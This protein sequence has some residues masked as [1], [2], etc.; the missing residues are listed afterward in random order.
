MVPDAGFTISRQSHRFVDRPMTYTVW[1]D[2]RTLA[3]SATGIPAL[4]VDTWRPPCSPRY[5]G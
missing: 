5:V 4:P 2:G 3:Q 1:I